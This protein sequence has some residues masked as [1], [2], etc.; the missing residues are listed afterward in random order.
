[1]SMVP[2]TLVRYSKPCQY[3]QYPPGTLC[4]VVTTMCSQFDLYEQISID[5]NNPNWHLIGTFNNT[6]KSP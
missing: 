3:D 6:P 5:E 1:M 4:K 2:L